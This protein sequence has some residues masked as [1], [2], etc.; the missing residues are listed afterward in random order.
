MMERLA[1]AAI[2]REPAMRLEGRTAVVVGVGSKIGRACATT[3]AREGAQ[4]LCVDPGAAANEVAEAIVG[5][6]GRAWPII[7]DCWSE[8]SAAQVR[9]KCEQLW[10]R[11]DVLLTCYSEKDYWALD[12]DSLEHWEWVIRAN[13]LGAVAFTKGLWSLLQQSGSASVV[14]L[15]SIDGVLGNPTIPAYSVSKAGLIPLAHMKAH[16]GGP[17]GIRVNYIA[18]AGHP[19]TGP[20]S[21]P[22]RRAGSDPGRVLA[23][24]PLGRLT[25][26]DELAAVAVFLASLDS[27]Y[28]TG[29]VIPVDGGRG[30]ITPGT[31][32]RGLAG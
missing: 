5:D 6:G 3:F 29:A 31:S 13:L 8:P 16:E 2:R 32:I 9:A 22:M 4:V 30:V 18:A 27:A 20:T 7:N 28:I 14:Y 19:Q 15:G 26:G 21:P 25:T 17:D 24:T 12:E 1:T 11:L 23:D 10:D